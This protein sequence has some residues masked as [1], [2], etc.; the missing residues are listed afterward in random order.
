MNIKYI[1][2][3]IYVDL[4]FKEYTISGTVLNQM[5]C[6]GIQNTKIESD[7]NSSSVLRTVLE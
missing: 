2:I 7:K 4:K 1:Y 6:K 3:Y 5:P